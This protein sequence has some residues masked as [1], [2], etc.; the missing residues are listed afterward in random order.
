MLANANWR[1]EVRKETVE[2]A[3]ERL[4]KEEEHNETQNPV[5]LKFFFEVNLF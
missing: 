5:F 3:A 1:D 2:L 4:R